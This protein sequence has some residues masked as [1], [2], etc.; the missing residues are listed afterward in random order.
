MEGSCD[1][2]AA[3]E[4]EGYKGVY[5]H[6]TLAKQKKKKTKAGRVLVSFIISA[7]KNTSTGPEYAI[8]INEGKEKRKKI[9]HM[10]SSPVEMVP[11]LQRALEVL[12]EIPSPPVP[13][14]EGTPK[15]ASVA[16]VIRV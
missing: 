12:A 3:A 5:R 8:R 2:V 13:S 7:T 10:D 9:N 4:V 11:A 14:P 1:R 15:R 6:H 16:L